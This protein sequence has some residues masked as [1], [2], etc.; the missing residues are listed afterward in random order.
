MQTQT[1]AFELW[2][3][4]FLNAARGQKLMEDFSR[5]MKGDLGSFQ[6]LFEMYAKWWGMDFFLR[7]LP[8]Y[9]SASIKAAEDFQKSFTGG[10]LSL[11]SCPWNYPLQS[12]YQ[13]LLKDYEELKEKT[14]R[15]EEE[16]GRL[17]SVLDE[18]LSLQGEGISAFQNLMK[19]QTQQFQDMMISFSKIF[20]ETAGTEETHKAA[21][22]ATKKGSRTRSKS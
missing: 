5:M 9:F 16:I 18:R 20:Q 15:Q 14:Q 21:E 7:D 22:A 19:K 11:M 6:D 13:A 8:E 17:R 1:Q 4:M 2:G 3:N 10:F 12:E